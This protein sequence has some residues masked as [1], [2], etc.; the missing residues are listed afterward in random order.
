ME[1]SLDS[2]TKWMVRSSMK[3]NNTKTEICLFYKND[4]APVMILVNNTTVKL[5]ATMCD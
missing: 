4:V 5:K 2:I 1:R 3:V